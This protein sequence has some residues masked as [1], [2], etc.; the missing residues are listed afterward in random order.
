MPRTYQV[1]QRTKD[2]HKV[3][4]NWYLFRPLRHIEGTDVLLCSLTSTLDGVSGQLHEP[5]AFLQ[6]KDPSEPIQEEPGGLQNRSGC[7]AKETNCLPCQES[8]YEFSD[9]QSA[10]YS[11]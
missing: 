3:K 6:G 11:L 8:K 4:V 10:A 9:V 2:I 5:A 7:L 1:L